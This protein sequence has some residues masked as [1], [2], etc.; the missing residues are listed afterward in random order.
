MFTEP[1]IR[2]EFGSCPP[3]SR[4]CF[5]GS[6]SAGSS[7]ITPQLARPAIRAPRGPSTP[8]HSGQRLL[9]RRRGDATGV[10]QAP[11]LLQACLEPLEAVDCV[12]AE[13]RELS[14]PV[15]RPESEL[16]AAAADEVD[17]GGLLGVVH[18]GPDRRQ[19]DGGADRHAGRAG[20]DRSGVDHRLGE[21]AV[22]EE[23]VLAQ[24]YTVEAELLRALHP[25]QRG[26][27]VLGPGP[28]PLWG[29]TDV[30]VDADAH[31]AALLRCRKPISLR[32]R[33][34]G[35]KLGKTARMSAMRALN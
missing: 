29:V 12:G 6:S 32:W 11:H 27:V 5:N 16:E 10:Q 26:L 28:S 3:S 23:V 33:A 35:T 34:P 30:L 14:R 4:P 15:A 8:A 31:G 25:P 1:A 21:V 2:A 19:R 20:R 22:L 24:E 18:R 17:H 9:D 7:H 13:R